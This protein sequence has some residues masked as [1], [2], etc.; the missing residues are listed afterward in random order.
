MGDDGEPLRDIA[1][2]GPDFR[3]AVLNADNPDAEDTLDI[4]YEKFNKIWPRLTV[5]GRC[6]ETDKKVLVTGPSPP[7]PNIRSLNP[8]LH[9]ADQVFASFFSLLAHTIP[10]LKEL[11]ELSCGWSNP[12][13]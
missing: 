11:R 5:V 2:E 13:F 7:P 6:S 1:M 9:R 12:T 10:D 8:I 4:D 3:A